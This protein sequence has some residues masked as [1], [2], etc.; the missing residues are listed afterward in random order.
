MN[1]LLNRV[2]WG[3]TVQNYLIALAVILGGMLLLRIIKK[4]VIALLKRW[5]EK[6]EG[7]LDDF[8][9][10][11]LEKN[12]LP[13][14][15]LG[16]VY[17]GLNY[18]TLHSKLERVVHIGY[19]L[20]I[21]F[22]A[23][24]LV[25]RFIRHGME[26]YAEQQEDADVK[27]KQLRSLMAIVKVIIWAIALILLLGN[28]GFNVTGI[29]AGLGIGG[30]AIALAAQTI[31]G[32]LFSYFVIFF[33]KPFE[34]GDFITLDDK[35]G[36]VEKVGLK[37]TRIRALTGEILIVSNTNLTN[38]RVHNYKQLER[39][40]VAFNIGVTYHTSAEKLRR[41]PQIIEQIV[42]PKEQITFDRAHFMQFSDFSLVF[43]IVYFV[44][45]AD[46]KFHM[47]K[48]EEI[49]IEIYEAF[50]KAGIEFAFPTQT[51]QI[52]KKV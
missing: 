45:I 21:T 39:R 24:R 27:K 28:L 46:L 48:Q 43:E 36:T 11:L 31:L 4:K 38:S 16:A 44:E 34:V 15:Y 30:I 29:V 35:K 33:D 2:Y 5:A 19:A 23:V 40:R 42:T 18:L 32:D 50:E 9:V 37:T 12:L 10:S 51:L 3:N 14:L 1:E 13:V 22:F 7:T 20:V 17:G 6:S 47:D 26:S 52:E 41:I 49:L 8:L 25:L